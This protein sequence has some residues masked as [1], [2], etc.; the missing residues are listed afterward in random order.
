M[1]SSRTRSC[2]V[3]RHGTARTRPDVENP[4]T[5]TNQP[6]FPLKFLLCRLKLETHRHT[7]HLRHTPL[8]FY[9][10]FPFSS[11][12]H[13]PS[14]PPPHPTPLPTPPPLVQPRAFLVLSPVV[15]VENFNIN[16][17]T[18]VSAT[19]NQMHLFWPEMPWAAQERAVLTLKRL[20]ASLFVQCQMFQRGAQGYRN[21]PCSS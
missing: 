21:P 19:F 12:L 4:T 3:I 17:H 1:T 16:T 13:P 20:R 14:R 5:P 9:L 2:D 8:P 15:C 11:S 18:R 7:H 6:S 10:P